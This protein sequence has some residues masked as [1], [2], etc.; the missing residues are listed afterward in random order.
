MPF[1]ERIRRKGEVYEVRLDTI[2]INKAVDPTAFNFPS[3]SKEPLPDIRQL[4]A[5]LQT[6]EDRVE[7]LLENYSFTQ[8]I[9]KRELTKQGVVL[10]TDS[11]TYHMSFY[12]GN[13]LKRLIEKNG[14][15]LSEKEQADEDHEISKRVEDIEKRLAKLDGKPD[16]EDDKR[17]SIAEMLR[18]S[19]LVNP[20]RERF[21]GREVIVFDF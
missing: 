20:R 8:K 17:I 16:A 14:K 12:K 2:E 13:R 5:E 15:P 4:L 7:A 11:E 3:I 6:N 10:E 21:R 19:N 9:I 18:A 1:F